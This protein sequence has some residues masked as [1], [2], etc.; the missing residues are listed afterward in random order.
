MSFFVGRVLSFFVCVRRVGCDHFFERGINSFC[1]CDGTAEGIHTANDSIVDPFDG[2][3]TENFYA[4]P[5]LVELCFV[6]SNRVSF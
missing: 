3:E 5:V 2:C 6:G 1:E 4:A